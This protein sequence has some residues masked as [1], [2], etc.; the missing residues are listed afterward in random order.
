MPPLTEGIAAAVITVRDFSPHLRLFGEALGWEVCAQATLSATE[1]ALLWGA[2]AAADVLVLAPPSAVTGRV[3]LV[4]FQGEAPPALGHPPLDAIGLFALDLYTRDLEE[5]R[6]RAEAAGARWAGGPASWQLGEPP[7]TVTVRQGLFHLAD[8]V[9][10]TAVMPG[11][12]RPTIAWQKNPSALTTELTS[13]VAC[14]P[15]V[16]TAKAFWGE[17][18]LGLVEQYDAEFAQP[19]LARMV[20]RPD[21]FAARMAFLAGSTTARLELVGRPTRLPATGWRALDR[22]PLQRPGRSVGQGAWVV[23]VRDLA[24]ARA[25]AATHGQLLGEPFQLDNPVYAGRAVL[26][27]LSPEGTLLELWEAPD[28]L[29]S[30]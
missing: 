28:L 4:R 9:N 18:G 15:D 30:L 1:T 14:V 20:G 12:P 21:S 8:D 29:S 13:V 5:L 2:A 25:V 6:A 23:A 11:H 7:H 10:V 3:H 24:A 19:E 26:P 27:V 22:R 16:D 17:G